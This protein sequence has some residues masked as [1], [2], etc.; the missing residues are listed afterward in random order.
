VSVPQKFS[1]N[2]LPGFRPVATR[3]Y[4]PIVALFK[5]PYPYGRAIERTSYTFAA[6]LAS[7]AVKRS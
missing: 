4:F 1:K 7:F 3:L 2:I 5:N 6:I